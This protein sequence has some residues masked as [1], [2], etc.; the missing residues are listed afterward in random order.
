MTTVDDLQPSAPPYLIRTSSDGLDTW[1]AKRLPFEPSGW[2]RQWRD[3][4]AGA[5]KALPASEGLRGVYTSADLHSVDPENV[6]F[7]NIGLASLNHLALRGIVFERSFS[8]PPPIPDHADRAPPHHHSYRCGTPNDRFTHWRVGNVLA[9]WEGVALPT[10]ASPNLKPTHV[11]AQ[12]LATAVV[13]QGEPAGRFG[14]RIR[15]RG[16]QGHSVSQL[17][18]PL[19]D[20]VVSSF[21]EFN[22]TLSDLLVARLAADTALPQESVAERLHS[23]RQAVLG[24]RRFVRTTGSGLAWNPRDDD[25]CAAAISAEPDGSPGM[26]GELFEVRPTD[27]PEGELVRMEPPQRRWSDAEWAQLRQGNRP[28]DMDDRWWVIASGTTVRIHR[29]WTGRLIFES[30]FERGTSDWG[31][32]Q[33]WVLG[34]PPTT[35]DTD[36]LRTIIDREV[37]G[38]LE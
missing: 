1:S 18:K 32:T 9:S 21:H 2:M 29:Y 37:L 38:L 20:G 3:E 6:L 33:A 7:Y 15:L 26:S 17:V 12:T 27:D 22:G 23:G 14:V 19:L 13:L 4:L 11:W 28:K 36:L 31:I 8:S 5:L 16:T 35:D 10:L 34:G 25:C 24:A 30:F